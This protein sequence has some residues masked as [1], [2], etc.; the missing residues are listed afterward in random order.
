MQHGHSFGPDADG[1]TWSFMGGSQ[2]LAGMHFNAGEQ[3]T[4]NLDLDFA[5]PE[6][7]HDWSVG[8][9][10]RKGAAYVYHSEGLP[11]TTLQNNEIKSKPPLPVYSYDAYDSWVN[12]HLTTKAY[13]AK[14]Y[15]EKKDNRK[16][17]LMRN[18]CPDLASFTFNFSF[19]SADWSHKKHVVATKSLGSFD[20]AVKC[21]D[22]GQTVSCSVKLMP[23]DAVGF[24]LEPGYSQYFSYSNKFA[25]L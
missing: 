4:F 9:W 25:Y 14:W 24:V 8:I 5:R 18:N 13:N 20:D 7:A 22:N 23:Q 10:G 1:V 6:L 3:K 11:T 16:W 12:D 21:T 15:E 17:I 19:T 2:E